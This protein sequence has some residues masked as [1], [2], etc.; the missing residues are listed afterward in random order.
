M[1]TNIDKLINEKKYSEIK[2]LL[3]DMN[4]YD[5][6]EII[7][8][9]PKNELVKVFRL[10]KKDIAADVFSYLDNDTQGTIILLLT[11]NEAVDI[12][13]DMSA[14]DATDLIDE[15][16]ANVVSRL[17]GK[18]NKDIR[19]NI[20]LLLKYPDN[21]AGGIMTVEYLD[22]KES[23]T[24]KEAINKIKR[25]HGNKETINTCFVTDKSRKLIGTVT[26]KDLIIN[27]EELTLSEVM[28]TDFMFVN[29]LDHQE[30]VVQKIRDYDL[31][32]IPVVDL[33]NKLVGI[34]TIDDVIDIIEEETTE[35]IEK[36]AAILPTEKSYMKLSVFELW[37][38]RI[39]WLLLLMISAAFTGK[40]IQN[41]ELALTS[42]VILTSFIPMLMNT[43]GN[44]GSQS[45]VT[46]IRGLSIGEV[47]YK[48]IFKV[49]F[50]E[51]K[52]SILVGLTLA[53]TNFIKLLVIDKVNLNIA[54]VVCTALVVTVVIAKLVGC[55]LPIISKKLGFDPAVMAN[56]FIST[57]V[58]AISLFVFFK[59]ALIILQI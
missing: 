25:E 35:D 1:I 45:S 15:M 59:T 37:K 31:T 53:L 12:I 2:H 52:V 38:S 34:I 43:G 46:I 29:T 33:E 7:E 13:N 50:K 24:I 20:N 23:S 26:L 44:A 47:S 56:P 11:D 51:F 22:L 27:K 41:Y 30:E 14:D 21:S 55:S 19:K 54:I 32:S 16:P 58:D 5:I 4:E 39:P 57:I 42:Y 40:I 9:L 10:L 48:D 49:M 8:K 17:L 6:S 36:M 28:D 18:V 3:G